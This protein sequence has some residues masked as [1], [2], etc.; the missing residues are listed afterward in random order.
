MELIT[1][2]LQIPFVVL[3]GFLSGYLLLLTVAAAIPRHNE[4]GSSPRRKKRRFTFIIPAHNE[5]KLITRTL[6]SIFNVRYPKNLYNVV[7]VADNCT[8]STADLARIS[9]AIVHERFDTGKQGKGAALN[10]IIARVTQGNNVCDAYIFID[11]D[12]T[13]SPNFINEMDHQLDLGHHAIQASSRVRETAD[14]GKG[15]L[16]AIA[17]FLFNHIRP[18]GR[19]RLG[20]SVGLRGNGMCFDRSLIS[21]IYWNEK[22]LVEDLDL[23]NRLLTEG[24]SVAFCPNAVVS[25]ELPTMQAGVNSQRMRWERGRLV[26]SF[27]ELPNLLKRAVVGRQIG[28]LESAFDLMLP[29]LALFGM[30]ALVFFLVDSVLAF[31]GY[32]KHIFVTILWGLTIAA[33][34]LHVTIGVIV[35]RKQRKHLVRDLQAFSCVP[36]Y[37]LW[38]VGLYW[39]MVWKKAPVHWTRTPR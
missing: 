30:V 29:P 9:G 2:V 33:V 23:A 7:V 3:W 12:S 39:A 38:K 17:Y 18:L 37:L 32:E 10:W 36:K 16:I 15:K 27:N 20:F 5:E 35:G 6:E 25:S 31:I 1:Y 34:I 14:S 19:S 21:R 26:S 8:D 4:L 22:S 28:L 13:I 24:I 11:A